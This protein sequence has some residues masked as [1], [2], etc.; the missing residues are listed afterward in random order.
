MRTLSSADIGALKRIFEEN[1]VVLDESK[2]QAEIIEFIT[3]CKAHHAVVVSFMEVMLQPDALTEVLSEAKRAK[4]QRTI[5]KSDNRRREL[6]EKICKFIF[7]KPHNKCN[8][9]EI[10]ASERIISNV[11][12]TF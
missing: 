5:Q 11:A 10:M 9:F 3:H 12:E 2:S 4:R 7:S 8:D 1:R 6:H